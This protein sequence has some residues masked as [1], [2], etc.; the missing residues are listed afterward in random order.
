MY[1]HFFEE[2]ELFDQ[3]AAGTSFAPWDTRNLLEAY[4]LYLYQRE[5]E[6]LEGIK[7]ALQ[8]IHD[9]GL[10]VGGNDRNPITANV[11]VME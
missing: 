2:L 1:D 9:D 6:Q 5:V 11:H 10:D 4:R 8:A 7:E 3:A